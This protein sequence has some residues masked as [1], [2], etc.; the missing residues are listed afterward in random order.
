MAERK[1]LSSAGNPLRP[2]YKHVVQAPGL[3][4]GYSAEVFPAILDS[5]RGGD[6][7][8]T[9]NQI[10]IAAACI[11]SAASSLLAP[12]SGKL[13]VLLIVGI[14]VGGFVLLVVVAGALVYVLKRRRAQYAVL[15][16]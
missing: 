4:L 16:S 6:N 9:Q 1:F 15:E 8:E 12:S 5:A 14:V 2:W 3:F 13:D 7:I 10:N 11:N